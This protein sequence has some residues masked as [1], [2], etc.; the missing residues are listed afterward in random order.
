MTKR[1]RRGKLGIKLYWSLWCNISLQYE[2][3]PRKIMALAFT[4]VDGANRVRRYVCVSLGRNKLIRVFVAFN[5]A[6]S[7]G[8]Y[9]F[10]MDI[11]R[12]MLKDWYVDA[13]CL[14]PHLMQVI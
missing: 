11:I 2:L 10:S 5:R 3:D 4:R 12:V 6:V 1:N 8:V 13:V 9:C 14:R 7:T